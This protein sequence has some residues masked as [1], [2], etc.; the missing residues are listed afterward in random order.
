[1]EADHKE[2]EKLEGLHIDFLRSI[3][4]LP[5]HGTPYNVIQ[6]EFGRYPL[7]TFWWKQVLGYR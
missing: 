1:M 3:S 5:K 2:F 4:G 6:T 7:R